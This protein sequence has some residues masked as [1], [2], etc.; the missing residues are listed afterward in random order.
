MVVVISFGTWLTVDLLSFIY[1]NGEMKINVHL[2]A[3]T[4]DGFHVYRRRTNISFLWQIQVDVDQLLCFI[5]ELYFDGTFDLIYEED[6]EHLYFPWRGII[7]EE[8]LQFLNILL[9]IFHYIL[10]YD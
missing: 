5:S 4:L 3:P 8:D 2:F 1:T 6:F 7:E 10:I 9:F